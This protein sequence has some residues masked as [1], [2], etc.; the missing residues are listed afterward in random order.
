[1]TEIPNNHKS[2][3]INIVGK[4]N[5]G[6]STLM[7]TLVGD[8]MSIIT[9]K[10]QTTRHRILGIVNDVESQ[11]I[12]S[13]SPGIISTIGYGMQ[14]TMNKFAYSS[15]ED[16]DILLFVTDKYDNYDK[17][18]KVV[19]ALAGAT[20][21]R[22]LIINKMDQTTEEEA[23]TVIDQWKEWL[24]FEEVHRISALEHAGTDELLQRI[25]DLLPLG[26]AYYPKDQITDKP[27]RFFVSEII[28]QHILQQYKQEIP[29]SCEV[30]VNS[31]KESEKDGKPFLRIQADIYVSRKSQKAIIIGKGGQAIKKLGISSR[32]DLEEWFNIG[33]YLEL[34]ARVKDN[35][36]DDERWLKQ[37]GY[38]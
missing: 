36:R 9:S 25:K 35:W 15:F 18:E 30:V 28:R 7:N 8:K 20:V 19:S 16:A 10:P 14:A 12:F 29:Y 34:N 37:F 2:G 17:D 13:D 1:M 11:I 4:P 32:A 26:P 23:Q 21:P 6:K 24:P 5:V 31:F 27:E 38:Q 33:I 22:F 3:Y